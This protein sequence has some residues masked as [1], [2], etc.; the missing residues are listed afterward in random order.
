MLDSYLGRDSVIPHIPK[1]RLSKDLNISHDLQY[2]DSEDTSIEA[3]RAS[4]RWV[5][6]NGEEKSLEDLY[7]DAWLLGIKDEDSEIDKISLYS[8]SFARG[9]S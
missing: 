2:L 9:G 4:F 5:L 7:K 3:T 6:N 8:G 1:D